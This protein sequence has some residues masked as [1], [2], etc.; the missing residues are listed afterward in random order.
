VCGYWYC[1]AGIDRP[2]VWIAPQNPR[3]EGGGE[4]GTFITISFP[5]FV[6]GFA[7][8]VSDDGTV[9]GYVASAVLG[10]RGF[11]YE[12]NGGAYALLS[13]IHP[14]GLC[15][16]T[17]I[18]SNREVCGYR[19]IG[20]KG[21]PVNPTTAFRWTEHDGFTDLGVIDGLG[22]AGVAI[23]DFGAVVVRDFWLTGTVALLWSDAARQ[24]I[25]PLPNGGTPYPTVISTR[26]VKSL[27]RPDCHT[28]AAVRHSA[29]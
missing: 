7:N 9:V 21:D 28:K 15:A 8:D 25:G 1:N 29:S 24:T 26:A 20:S 3:A 5:G 17:G 14:Q 4:G 6:N 11:V 27:K 2:F 16:A 18:N 22:T 13:S 12:T 19:S 23:D 10:Q